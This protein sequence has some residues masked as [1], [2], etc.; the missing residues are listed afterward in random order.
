MSKWK[1]SAAINIFTQGSLLTKKEATKG[2]EERVIY[3]NITFYSI[4]YTF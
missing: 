2:S 3:E 4:L 1:M